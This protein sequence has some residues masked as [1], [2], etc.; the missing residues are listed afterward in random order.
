MRLDELFSTECRTLKSFGRPR[1]SRWYLQ[2]DQSLPKLDTRRSGKTVTRSFLTPPPFLRRH[3]LQSKRYT[4]VKSHIVICMDFAQTSVVCNLST[5]FNVKY[6]FSLRYLLLTIIC[7]LF[8]KKKKKSLRLVAD[9]KACALH[10]T[11]QDQLRGG[12]E[13]DFRPGN[14]RIS[15]PHNIFPENCLKFEN[16]YYYF[17][18]NYQCFRPI[19]R[20]GGGNQ[21]EY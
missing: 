16:S 11:M 13:R 14:Y 2:T 4:I 3:R 19:A 5:Q 18:I 12:L 15:G 6:L 7:I 17:I 8:L 10:Y 20:M 9:V 21:F 1:P